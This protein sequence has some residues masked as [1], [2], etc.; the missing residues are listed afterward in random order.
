MRF[1][2]ARPE[3]LMSLFSCALRPA[4]ICVLAVFFLCEA[5]PIYAQQRVQGTVLDAATGESLPGAT[6]Q[7]EG[8]FTGTVANAVGRF[9]LGVSAFPVSIVTRFIGYE[10]DRRQ[11][12]TAS[13][14]LI[15]IHLVPVAIPLP[16]ITV[17]GEDPAIG[18]MRR[19]IEEKARW[20]NSFDTYKVDAYNRFRLE[21]D[22]GIVS[23]WE[24]GTVAFW[25]R[26]RGT[27]EISV[28]QRQTDN[29]DIDELLPAALFVQNLYDDDIDVAGHRFMGVTHP[30]ALSYYDFHLS[31]TRARDNQL[32]YDIEVQ[33]KSKLGSGFVGT[34]AVLDSAYAMLDVDLAPG[35]AFFFPPPIKGLSVAY[36]Q[37]FSRF[38]SDVWLPVDFQLSI[39]L[40]I[41][42]MG[43]IAIPTIRIEQIS[44]LS[45]FELNVQL[46]DSLY[47]LDEFI[48]AD[49]MALATMDIAELEI[50]PVPLTP[51]EEVA[52]ETIDS[53]MTLR[54]A[55]R[56]TGLLARFAEV[57]VGSSDGDDSGGS[58]GMGFGSSLSLDLEPL[59]WYNRVEGLHA[60]L[61]ASRRL[62][63][64]FRLTGQVGYETARKGWTYGTSARIGRR[65]WFEGGFVD[66]VAQRYESDFL[67]RFWNSLNVLAT[68][69]DYFDYM[70]ERKWYMAGGGAY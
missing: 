11:L 40:D 57:S 36:R 45:D 19:V 34:I 55:Y 2:R 53:T 14:D 58:G 35:D 60:G 43:L 65:T 68:Q 24:S 39:R 41:S 50:V 26:E 7:I 25:D 30:D 21:N 63:E 62:A 59:L 61:K 51:R 46:P 18:I 64:D 20:R 8:T 32:V 69:P 49:S 22:S 17:S 3:G 66:H 13:S 54:K 6:V 16:E 4:S 31:G 48:V 67:N 29:M 44:R 1:K 23:I 12:Q 56:P 47:D 9:S 37:Q 10:S 33:P 42:F 28:W 70:H 52:Y 38:G 15:D 5:A 27:R